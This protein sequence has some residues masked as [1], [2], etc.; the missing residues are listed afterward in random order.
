MEKF[1]YKVS[2]IIPCYNIGSKISKALDSICSQSYRKLE[3][4]IVDD[5]SDNI[6]ELESIISLYS[7]YINIKLIRLLNNVGGG[8]ARNV[9]M[10]ASSGEFIALLDADDY[11]GLDK[12][13]KQINFYIENKCTYKDILF[14]NISIVNELD[15]S[16]LRECKT[17]KMVLDYSYY[18]FWCG[19]LIQTSSLFFNREC[20]DKVLFNK[21][22]KRHQDYDFCLTLNGMGGVFHCITDANTYWTVPF[23]KKISL[24][25][26]ANVY[27]SFL[28]YSEYK[29]KMGFLGRV[30]FLISS[31]YW[32]GCAE[33]KLS[34]TIS[35]SFK[36]CGF[37]DLIAIVFISPI[38][39]FKKIIRKIKVV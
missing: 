17:S 16:I 31:A 2:V 29:K 19:G 22:L 10:I 6:D 20:I 8:E 5:A 7:N 26:G 38:F 23:D 28:F 14:T 21:K 30:G 33:G 13:E 24:T 12:I 25:K 1:N 11:W 27:N 3:V 18:V 15:G 35:L 34:E 32:V 36:Y 4:I 37:I 9:G 39:F